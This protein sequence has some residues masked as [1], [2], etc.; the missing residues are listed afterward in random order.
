MHI[1]ESHVGC[2][3]QNRKGE[4]KMKR[5]FKIGAIFQII[6]CLCCLIVVICMPLY[7]AFYT[8]TF[9][10][11]CFKI[12]ATITFISTFNPIGLIGIILSCIGFLGSELKKRAKYAI[13]T[14]VLSLFV[15]ISWFIA[16]CFFVHYSGGV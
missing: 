7:R 1:P 10:E 8:T 15:P 16:V 3:L 9:G 13:A 11:I 5:L 4:C 14:I 2:I 12:G 6:Y